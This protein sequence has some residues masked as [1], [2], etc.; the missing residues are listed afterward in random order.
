MNRFA[1]RLPIPRSFHGD[2]RALAAAQAQRVRPAGGCQLDALASHVGG[3][4]FR[5]GNAQL[6][7]GGLLVLEIRHVHHHVAAAL[8]ALFLEAAHQQRAVALDGL[9]GLG[10]GILV[11]EPEIGHRAVI[12]MAVSAHAFVLHIH[13]GQGVYLLVDLLG[14][15]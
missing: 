4:G 15:K 6:H 7:G 13:V 11:V 8:P 3:D 9:D 1:G 2:K 14:A 10:A 12:P 5:A